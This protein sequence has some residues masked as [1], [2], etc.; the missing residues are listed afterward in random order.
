MSLPVYSALPPTGVSGSR[1][2]LFS[3]DHTGK[4]ITEFPYRNMQITNMMGAQGFT[5][6]CE[7]P[8]RGSRRISYANL[9][10]GIHDLVAYDNL[11]NIVV[12]AGP[13]WDA[14]ASSSTGVISVSAQDP[15]TYLA[16][17][18]LKTTKVYVGQAPTAIV[19]D[20][21][22]YMNSVRSTNMNVSIQS[23]NSGTVTVTYQARDRNKIS[24]LIQALSLMDNGFD[25]YFSCDIGLTVQYNLLVYG[26]L[27]TP[28][29]APIP[30]GPSLA[31]GAGLMGYSLQLNAQ[32]LTNDI[33]EIA[34]DQ[35]NIQNATDATNVTTYNA[36]YQSAETNDVTTPTALTTIA[37]KRI[38]ALSTTDQ[39]PTMV[40]KSS[41][42][43]GTPG[44][45]FDMG[46]QLQVVIN[47]DWA[48]YYG[49]A[50]VVGYQ[51]TPGQ[52]D[53]TSVVIYQQDLSAVS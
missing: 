42:V 35:S 13:L 22:T 10:P 29:N 49:T 39:N 4:I 17:R 6:T 45:D 26:G 9:Y 30:V 2:T 11:N 51:I 47:D 38:K 46:S 28:S 40:V 3:A 7:I 32:T 19:S 12:F 15:L 33:D 20:L 41:L 16:K 34:S 48:Q 23:A 36:L 24:D 27:I 25:Y 31:T 37:N 18:L 14:T 43:S 52:G 8:Y 50:R 44:V 53:G 21:F 1:Y 5:M